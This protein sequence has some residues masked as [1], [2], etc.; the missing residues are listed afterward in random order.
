LAAPSYSHVAY[1][2]EAGDEGFKFAVDGKKGSSEWFVLSAVIVRTEID[3]ATTKL[4]DR[5]RAKLGMPKVRTSLP[6]SRTQ[7][8]AALHR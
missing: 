2:D 8:A 6:T 5:V 7:E 1:I 4:V 3:I